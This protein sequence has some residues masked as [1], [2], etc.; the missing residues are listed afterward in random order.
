MRD[1]KFEIITCEVCVRVVECDEDDLGKR[2]LATLYTFL[3]SSRCISEQQEAGILCKENAR[4]SYFLPHGVANEH[5]AHSQM[6]GQ[7]GP[8]IRSRVLCSRLEKA[9]TG[10]GL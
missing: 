4:T 5:W 3:W 10:S 2:G 8:R 9:L 7:C 1:G 6:T